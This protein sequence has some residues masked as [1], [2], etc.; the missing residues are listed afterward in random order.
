MAERVAEQLM[1]K[2]ALTAHVRDELGI[3]ETIQA[4]PIQAALTSAGTFAVGAALPM[5]IVFLAPAKQMGMMVA[6]GSLFFLALLGGLAASS[7][8][9]RVMSACSVSD[10][11]LTETYSPAAIDMAPATKPAIPASNTSLRP[12]FEAATPTTRLAVETI[13]SLAPSTA[14]RNQ[15][16]C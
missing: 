10:W 16:I 6:G 7:S 2:D 15:P 3:S 14:A 12:A 8:F 4:N 5:L 9:S 13:P 1:A 11:E